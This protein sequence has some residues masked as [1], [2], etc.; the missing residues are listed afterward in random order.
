MLTDFR[1]NISLFLTIA[2][3]LFLLLFFLY[4]GFKDENVTISTTDLTGK[5]QYALVN[6]DKGA[7]F[8]GK[9]IH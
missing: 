6:E 2:A 9:I 7:V 1:R 5:M 4:L 8:E 3:S